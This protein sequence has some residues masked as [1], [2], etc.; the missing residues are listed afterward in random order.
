[1]NLN[2]L[3]TYMQQQGIHT[4]KELSDAM[5]VHPV[6]VYR[7]RHN[8]AQPGYRFVKGLAQAFPGKD[9]GALLN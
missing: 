4:D 2:L 5:G 9:I 3:T 7:V 8:K 1:M 6:T